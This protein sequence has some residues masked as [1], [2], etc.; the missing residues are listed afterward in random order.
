[1]PVKSAPGDRNALE[2]HRTGPSDVEDRC[3]LPGLPLG[4]GATIVLLILS[5]D[6]KQ[7]FLFLLD[8]GYPGRSPVVGGRRRFRPGYA[9]GMILPTT[10]GITPTT[11]EQDQQHYDDE[12]GRGAHER[13]LQCSEFPVGRSSTMGCINDTLHQ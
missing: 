11:T 10:P 12:D 13:F 2:R 6:F 5:V 7:D 1:M 9:Q 3:G 8:R 4:F